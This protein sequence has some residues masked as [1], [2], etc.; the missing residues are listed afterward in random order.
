MGRQADGPA[1]SS[2]GYGYTNYSR[3]GYCPFPLTF[4]NAPG[5]GR[6]HTAGTVPGR[7]GIA[8]SSRSR[9][10]Q[11][12]VDYPFWIAG[13][14]CQKG[15][16]FTSGGQPGHTAAWE[17]DACIVSTRGFFRGTGATPDSAWLRPRYDGFKT[18]QD[19]ACDIF[20]RC[21]RC[22]AEVTATVAALNL[23]CRESRK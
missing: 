2:F 20:H 6:A 14:V 8:V 21:L 11:V 19:C 18:L 5:I 10:P 22:E 9:H 15:L 17:D 3:D 4:A 12:A 16:Y 7:T 23:A 13:A 1:Y